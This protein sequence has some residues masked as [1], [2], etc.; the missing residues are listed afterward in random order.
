MSQVDDDIVS[1]RSENPT[2]ADVALSRV[3][4]RTVLGAGSA[5]AALAMTGGVAALL[6]VVPAPAQ[7]ADRARRLLGFEGIAPSTDDAAK[8]P[9]GYTASVLI[10]WGDPVSDGP[11]F[12]PDASNSALSSSRPTNARCSSASSTRARRRRVPMTRPI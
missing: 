11:E 4:R 5:S 3:T 1:N 7:G 6:K 8:V 2:L 12:R 9:R 10:A